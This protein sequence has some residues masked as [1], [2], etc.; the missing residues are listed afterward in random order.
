MFKLTNI[1]PA[2]RKRDG[3]KKATVLLILAAFAA[4]IL[5]GGCSVYLL[6]NQA[7][8]KQTELVSAHG[9][10]QGTQNALQRPGFVVESPMPTT[11]PDA[12][13]STTTAAAQATTTVAATTTRTTITT[14]TQTTIPI[15]TTVVMQNISMEQALVVA[16]QAAG[17][18]ENNVVFKRVVRSGDTPKYEVVFFFDGMIYTYDVRRSDGVITSSNKT[19]AEDSDIKRF[20]GDTILPMVKARE[21]ALKDA[22]LNAA[23][24]TRIRLEKDDGVLYYKLE[25]RTARMEYKYKIHASTGVVL[26]RDSDERD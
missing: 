13:I 8:P 16:L 18:A 19:P 20:S 23:E 7:A 3:M 25:F 5:I 1:C 12:E 15:E 17:L 21:V 9:Q 2:A 4:G 24:F 14:S 22:K 6:T 26:D 11:V 10:P